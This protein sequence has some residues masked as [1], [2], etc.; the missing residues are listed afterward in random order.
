MYV[1]HVINFENIRLTK[2]GRKLFGR[3]PVACGALLV[4]QVLSYRDGVPALNALYCLCA[5][6]LFDKNKYG[7]PLL[8]DVTS[9]SPQCR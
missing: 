4:G 8:V 1:P 3:I 7:N 6:C 5:Y 9:S 2:P